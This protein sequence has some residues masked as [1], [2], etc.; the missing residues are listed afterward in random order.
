MKEF[1]DLVFP[2][3]ACLSL[4]LD[5]FDVLHPFDHLVD[6]LIFNPQPQRSAIAFVTRAACSHALK[7]VVYPMQLLTLNKL[8]PFSLDIKKPGELEHRQGRR[9]DGLHP[10]VIQL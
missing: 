4:R 1:I 10:A 8:V 2:A 3:L 7:F 9:I 5:K 6:E